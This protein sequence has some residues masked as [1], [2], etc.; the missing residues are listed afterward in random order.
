M[1]DNLKDLQE[2]VGT[3]CLLTSMRHCVDKI[4]ARVHNATTIGQRETCVPA[5]DF[6]PLLHGGSNQV[7]PDATHAI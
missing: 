5:T 7:P 3:F 6:P 4:Q 1:Y 2:I